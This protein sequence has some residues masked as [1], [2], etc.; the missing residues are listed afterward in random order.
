MEKVFEAKDP[1]NTYV[2]LYDSTWNNHILPSHSMMKDHL[3]DIKDA[4]ENPDYIYE[5]NKSNPP[6]DYRVVYIKGT[7]VGTYFDDSRKWFTK[8]VSSNGGN[9]G[10]VVTAFPAPNI[11]QGTNGEEPIYEASNDD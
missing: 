10:E 2:T 7:K 3:E 1:N 4:I 6:L 9:H 11:M 8:V 5:S